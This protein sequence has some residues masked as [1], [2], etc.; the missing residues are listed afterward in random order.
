[1]A[2]L[3]YV[4]PDV[5]VRAARPSDTEAAL[6]LIYSAGPRVFEFL[7]GTHGAPAFQFLAY[8]FEEGGGLFGHRA[9]VAAVANGE[10][11]GIGAFYGGGEVLGLVLGTSRQSV[12]HFGAARGAGVMR[13]MMQLGRISPAPPRDV[14]FVADLGVREAL[15]G[16]GIGT[17]LLAHQ[18]AVARK[19]RRRYLGLDVAVDNPQAQALYERLGFRV[20]RERKPSGR[21]AE[22]IPGCKRMMLRLGDEA[23]PWEREV[24]G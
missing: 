22:C 12:R 4:Q 20:L 7:F 1:V 14:H 5:Q 21:L 10:L 6:P 17:R 9:H 16:R 8:A 11:A 18:A 24:K 13:R 19:R 15:R 2:V 3:S 23:L